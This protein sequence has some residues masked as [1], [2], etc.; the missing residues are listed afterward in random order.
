MEAAVALGI[1]HEAVAFLVLLPAV[2]DILP[3]TLGE[4]VVIHEVVARVVRLIN[5][6]CLG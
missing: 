2:V 5:S 6:P 3:G 4:V 1:G